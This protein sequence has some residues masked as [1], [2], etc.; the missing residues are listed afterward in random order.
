MQFKRETEVSSGMNGVARDDDGQ[1]VGATAD[2]TRGPMAAV[3]PDPGML[4]AFEFNQELRREIH[5]RAR[6]G[7]FVS[8]PTM[9]MD[10][11]IHQLRA[12]HYKVI[13]WSVL[14]SIQ[15][16]S[17][18]GLR[19]QVE[20]KLKAE[21]S[22]SSNGPS[23]KGLSIAFAGDPYSKFP[24]GHEWSMDLNFDPSGTAV[25]LYNGKDRLLSSDDWSI[26]EPPMKI[27]ADIRKMLERLPALRNEELSERLEYGEL[28][29]GIFSGMLRDSELTRSYF[30]Q[31]RE[32]GPR[33]PDPGP[34]EPWKVRDW[35]QSQMS[36]GE[37]LYSLDTE[38]TGMDLYALDT[39]TTG[40][41]GSVIDVAVVN[42]KGEQVYQ[43]HV[44]P[45]EPI[46]PGATKVHGH[47]DESL[48]ALGARPWSEVSQELR[49]V[50]QG[51]TVVQYA[52]SFFDK[53]AIERSDDLAGVRT[54]EN[55]QWLDAM[56]PYQHGSGH[57][58]Q[59]KLIEAAQDL[60][61][62]LRPEDA[63][64][65]LADAKAAM[66]VFQK[67]AERPLQLKPGEV[68]LHK[69]ENGLEAFDQGGE[70][71]NVDP[72]LLEKSL[73]VAKGTWEKPHRGLQ[74]LDKGAYI[75]VEL[76]PSLA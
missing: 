39:E 11:K 5:E 12:E 51:K 36:K 45:M 30:S 29:K 10:E 47:T 3:G 9:G 54:A 75:R 68:L 46:D 2:K 61:V 64:G 26:D 35:I 73:E 49:N 38:T 67:M 24:Q 65:A 33:E 25:E 13:A 34:M 19:F 15:Q 63:H 31:V 71:L 58:K 32:L 16:A 66:G 57:Y 55:V 62:E 53:A 74:S 21:E 7:T 52:D 18:E 50:L 70:R 20:G 69:G 48:Q 1:V 43:A 22:V 42:Q 41:N 40:F 37:D 8:N 44:L 76:D 23:Y 72:E 28:E 4:S 56:A 17:A 59:M 6:Q 60:G 14:N 27:A